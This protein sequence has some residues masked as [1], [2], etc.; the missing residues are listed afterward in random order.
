EDWRCTE[1][2]NN[3]RC[4]PNANSSAPNYR[5]TAIKETCAEANFSAV[6]RRR[7][8]LRRGV[9]VGSGTSTFLY[10]F[11]SCVDRISF[12][13]FCLHCSYFTCSI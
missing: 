4:T 11:I 9:G 12:S 10:L 2:K 5:S 3:R 1:E 7:G 8:P 13:Q 6:P